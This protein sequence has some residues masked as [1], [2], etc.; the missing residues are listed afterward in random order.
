VSANE[1][2]RCDVTAAASANR[3][4]PVTSPVRVETTQPR[5][6]TRS[7]RLFSFWGGA[8]GKRGRSAGRGARVEIVGGYRRD[9]RGT[10]EEKGEG[11]RKR[12]P[13]AAQASPNMGLLIPRNN[14]NCPMQNGD[15]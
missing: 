6:G 9:E 7:R 15:R 3:V 13:V 5:P 10:D 11:V 1:R 2:A 12:A 8:A 14:G 4:A